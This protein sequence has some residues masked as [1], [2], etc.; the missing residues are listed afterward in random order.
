M[1]PPKRRRAGKNASVRKQDQDRKRKIE[2]V[3]VKR[4]RAHFGTGNG[5]LGYEITSVESEGSGFDL[6]M[7]KGDVTLCVEVKGRSGDEVTAEFSSNES[8]TIVN[9]QK[10]N[11]ER[12]DYR[13]CIVTDALNERG[14]REIHHFSWW[15]NKNEWINVEGSSEKLQF[16]PSGA[17]VARISDASAKD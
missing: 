6:L 9:H 16:H 4:V 1:D 8:L 7:T 3:A 17:T 11:F 13:V 10:G 12:G 2:R 5:G 14:N 15:P